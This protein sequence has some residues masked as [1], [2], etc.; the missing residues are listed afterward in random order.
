MKH[1]L[2]N[3]VLMILAAGLFTL[4]FRYWTGDF[5]GYLTIPVR[6]TDYGFA[7]IKSSTVW[8]SGSEFTHI[9]SAF[10]FT[11]LIAALAWLVYQVRLVYWSLVSNKRA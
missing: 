11:A 1:R 5:Q 10:V 4:I 6:G 7:R 2:F 8:V 9:P 3:V